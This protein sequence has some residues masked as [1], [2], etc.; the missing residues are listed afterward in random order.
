[1]IPF[2]LRI[3]VLVLALVAVGCSRPLPTRGSSRVA[4]QLDTIAQNVVAGKI[5][6]IEVTQVS[7]SRE[8]IVAVSPQTLDN[9]WDYQFVIRHELSSR[10]PKIASVLKAAD[11]DEASSFGDLRWKVVFYSSDNRSM[12]ELYFDGAG[13][14]GLVNKIPVSYRLDFWVRL[15]HALDLSFDALP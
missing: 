4:A 9:V 7:L 11:V 8:F 15:R 12:G 10:G 6:I 14:K 13:R 5:G 3:I 2:R 1:M